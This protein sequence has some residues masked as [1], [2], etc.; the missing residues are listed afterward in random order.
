MQNLQTIITSFQHDT[1]RHLAWALFSP[2]LLDTPSCDFIIEPTSQRLQWLADLDKNLPQSL[3]DMSKN[4]FQL[5]R[6][7]E[8]LW[9][10]FF[11]ND[12]QFTLLANNI[13]IIKKGKT[14]GEMDFLIQDK[15]FDK[16]IHLEVAIKFYVLNTHIINPQ[17]EDYSIWRGPNT[18]DT[19]ERKWH[20][21]AYQQTQLCKNDDVL[22][23]LTAKNLPKPD[24][25]K[26]SLKGYLYRPKHSLLK[27][28]H[29]NAQQLIGHTYYW[30]ELPI[31]T[32]LLMFIKIPKSDW[33]CSTATLTS[34]YIGTYAI[35]LEALAQ[36]EYAIMVATLLKHNDTWIEFERYF[37]LPTA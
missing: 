19:L 33:I 10:Y 8:K 1:V 16:V 4:T 18:I 32:P 17:A 5:G 34:E 31:S 24:I 7:Y 30:Q 14:L 15:L 28:L 22:D 20:Q 37:L 13:Q 12:S 21:L 25:S 2:S 36:Q 3:L 23:C 27:P 35:S 11:Q 26:I 29:A 9:G 6:Y